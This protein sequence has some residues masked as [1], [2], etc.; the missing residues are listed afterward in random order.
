MKRKG[1]RIEEREKSDG[2]LKEGTVESAAGQR[3]L[4]G[5]KKKGKE[6]GREEKGKS[7]RETRGRGEEEGAEERKKGPTP[8]QPNQ[9]KEK[10][11]GLEAKR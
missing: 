1:A 4:K 9:P 5:K 11:F 7:A 3:A 6:E 10:R 8:N 2:G